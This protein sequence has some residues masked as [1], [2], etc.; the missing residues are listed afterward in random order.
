MTTKSRFCLP[1]GFQTKSAPMRARMYA[2]A[3][4]EFRNPELALAHLLEELATEIEL[5]QQTEL[6]FR[7]RDAPPPSPP[8]FAIG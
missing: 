2:I 6:T 4:R 5:G 7:G 1:A 8:L 3:L